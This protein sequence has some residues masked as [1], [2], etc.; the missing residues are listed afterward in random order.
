MINP[1]KIKTQESESSE[2]VVLHVVL[3]MFITLS[4]AWLNL[5]FFF[6]G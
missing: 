2:V 1:V 5:Y 4:M 6:G 3:V